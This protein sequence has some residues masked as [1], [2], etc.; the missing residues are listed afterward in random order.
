[1]ER[2]RSPGVASE[3][4]RPGDER[5][6]LRVGKEPGHQAEWNIGGVDG[7]ERV[8][9]DDAHDGCAVGPKLLEAQREGVF[10]RPFVRA[11]GETTAGPPD[12]RTAGARCELGHLRAATADDPADDG[13]DAPS[14]G[15]DAFQ[16]A[17]L[18][19]P[20][21][22]GAPPFSPHDRAEE[23]VGEDGGTSREDRQ[24]EERLGQD[25][26]GGLDA[27]IDHRFVELR[28]VVA[29]CD[30]SQGAEEVGG[31]EPGT[32]DAEELSAAHDQSGAAR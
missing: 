5:A 8:A 29:L 31:S 4:A 2:R 14:S 15:A 11:L 3:L 23:V 16:E 26:R 17:R 19:E 28:G 25:G 18:A 6:D 7:A 22:N 30:G 9:A 1:L 20:V 27:G 12:C 24:C 21:S 32:V 10:V 13:W